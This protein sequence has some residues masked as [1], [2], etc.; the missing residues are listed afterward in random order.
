MF[1][2]HEARPKDKMTAV[3]AAN[4]A[5]VCIDLCISVL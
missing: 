3:S 2:L 4:A 1:L 5:A